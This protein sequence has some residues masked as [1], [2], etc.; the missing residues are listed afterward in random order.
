MSSGHSADPRRQAL[1]FLRSE[2]RTVEWLARE[3]GLTKNGVRVHLDQLER[4]GLIRRSGVVRRA[5]AGKPPLLYAITSAGESALSQA[6]VPVLTALAGAVKHLPGD[7]ARRTFAAAGRRLADEIRIP[8]TDDPGD[9]AAGVLQSLGVHPT[10]ERSASGDRAIVSGDAC[11][12]TAAVRECHESCELV[13]AMLA[14]A[15]GATVSTRCD[16][17][18]SPRC[19]FEVTRRA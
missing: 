8:S 17:D 5:Q 19:R 12:L 18:G 1:H 4:D 9:S 2:P 15:T 10:V 13:R 11:P 7:T 16:Y 6:Y 3:L 14:Q